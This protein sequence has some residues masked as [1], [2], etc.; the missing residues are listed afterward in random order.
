MSTF[1]RRHPGVSVCAALAVAAAALLAGAAGGSGAAS[2]QATARPNVVVIQTDDQTLQELYA[3]W[4]TPA[5]I[6]A[7]VMPNTLDMIGKEGITFSRYYASYPLCCPSRATLLSGR[8]AHSNGVI[9]NDTQL[10]GKASAT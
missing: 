2:A 10:A 8:Y 1:S 3:T 6:D 9:S 5:G 7:R 4:R